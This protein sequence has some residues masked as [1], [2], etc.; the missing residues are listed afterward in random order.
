MQ[1]DFQYHKNVQIALKTVLDNLAHYIDSAASEKT[2]AFAAKKLLENE[3]QKFQ[4]FHDI[5]ICVSS[6]HDTKRSQT[7]KY[8]NPGNI[9]IG[10]SNL[11]GVSLKSVDLACVG[12]CSRSYVLENDN[13]V[14]E[15][16][17]NSM[18]E[19]LNTAYSI[20]DK[21]RA[22]ISADTQFNELYN[23]SDTLLASTEFENIIDNNNFGHSVSLAGDVR[24]YIE[25]HNLSKL[26]EVDFFSYN[27]HI[28]KNNSSWGFRYENTYFINQHGNLEEL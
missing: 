8:C 18:A 12:D 2:I 23:F 11:I 5:Q 16:I 19:G 9:K 13:I 17:T 25:K 20:H 27:I 6:G 1:R 26:N 21:M 4:W 10:K 14:Q 7:S 22:Y 28:C 24:Q 3:R 15:P